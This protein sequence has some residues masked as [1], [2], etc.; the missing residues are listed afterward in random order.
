MQ[1]GDTG[2]DGYSGIPRYPGT[3]G[4][5]YPGTRVPVLHRVGTGGVTRVPGYMH[6]V[7][8]GTR[9]TEY[10]TSRSLAPM[11]TIPTSVA[12]YQCDCSRIVPNPTAWGTGWK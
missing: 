3:R 4:T 8:P 1:H 10:W 5:G 11:C 6:L 7:P 2:Y 12:G 9:S